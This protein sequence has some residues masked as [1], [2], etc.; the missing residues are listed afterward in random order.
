MPRTLFRGKEIRWI[1]GFPDT[2]GWD[3][4]TCRSICCTTSFA[5][6]TMCDESVKLMKRLNPI[7][8]LL[9]VMSNI[10]TFTGK[11]NLILRPRKGCLFY[12]GGCCIMK[13]ETG[14]FP[15]ECELFPL[16]FVEITNGF[17]LIYVNC[18]NTDVVSSRPLLD[19]YLKQAIELWLR[20]GK[21]DAYDSTYYKYI[22]MK[23]ITLRKVKKLSHAATLYTRR[24]IDNLRSYHREKN[25]LLN[26]SY[27][28]E[29]FFSSL[30]QDIEQYFKDN[31]LESSVKIILESLDYVF[32]WEHYLTFNQLILSRKYQDLEKLLI[33]L[34]LL[35]ISF[36]KGV[37]RIRG[38]SKVELNDFQIAR[39]F[40]AST[41][42]RGWYPWISQKKYPTLFSTLGILFT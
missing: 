2:T 17:I 20:K 22:K 32:R 10:P 19:D 36:S 21:V 16:Q 3:C 18:G 26:L 11:T 14:R 8:N 5:P 28:F 7:Y 9:N 27:D 25:S 13:D 42:L 24:K 30:E 6:D 37:A 40:V 29:N 1:R 33:L 35:L 12:K 15:I 34:D 41:N 31:I 39:N 23:K 4:L 38:H